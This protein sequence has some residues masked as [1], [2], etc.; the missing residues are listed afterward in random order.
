MKVVSPFLKDSIFKAKTGSSVTV[1]GVE[2]QVDPQFINGCEHHILRAPDG[3]TI[4]FYD[5]H[6]KFESFSHPVRKNSRTCLTKISGSTETTISIEYETGNAKVQFDICSEE[7]LSVL[8]EPL[9]RTTVWRTTRKKDFLTSS[10]TENYE[11]IIQNNFVKSYYSNPF[12]KPLIQWIHLAHQLAEIPGFQT[13]KVPDILLDDD[14]DTT[15]CPQTPATVRAHIVHHSTR[16]NVYLEW[17]GK[18]FMEVEFS[19][20]SSDVPFELNGLLSFNLQLP[21]LEFSQVAHLMFD[22]G[23]LHGVQR[24]T[25]E[26]PHIDIQLEGHFEMGEFCTPRLDESTPAFT[27]SL[28]DKISGRK[29]VEKHWMVNGTYHRKD[30]PSFTHDV[31]TPNTPMFSKYWEYLK[32]GLKH[33]TNGPQNSNGIF[34][35]S[36]NISSNVTRNLPDPRTT[37]ISHSFKEYKEAIETTHRES[38]GNVVFSKFFGEHVYSS[39][40][41]IYNLDGIGTARFEQEKLYQLKLDSPPIDGVKKLRYFHPSRLWEIKFEDGSK[42]DFI[43]DQFHEERVIKSSPSILNIVKTSSSTIPTYALYRVVTE[44]LAGAFKLQ[45]PALIEL[46]GMAAT[47]LVNHTSTSDAVRQ[48]CESILTLA[49][50]RGGRALLDEVFHKVFSTPHGLEAFERLPQQ[51]IALEDH[52]KDEFVRFLDSLDQDLIID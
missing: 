7:K 52:Q 34:R 35:F 28:L 2:Y 14:T 48:K 10:K 15:L 30:N 49:M 38:L 9:F 3:G 26:S 19:R 17:G 29:D 51:V 5:K 41:Y 16:S 18:N 23:R 24:L 40:T 42:M 8:K 11:T 33:R 32:T 36:N 46:L 45:H 27:S 37:N 4:S 50:H 47:V 39:E 21:N 43:E 22:E 6:I 1:D 25:K 12:L 44:T 20:P 13:I 31:S